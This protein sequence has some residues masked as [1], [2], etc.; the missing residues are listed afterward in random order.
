MLMK[1][2]GLKLPAKERFSGGVH[3]GRLTKSQ[4]GDRSVS[5]CLSYCFGGKAYGISNSLVVLQS[6]LLKA[7]C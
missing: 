5:K 3:K 6:R 2:Y 4:R 1:T 7:C